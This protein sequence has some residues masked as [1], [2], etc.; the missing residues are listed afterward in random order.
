MNP[1]PPALQLLLNPFH[2]GRKLLERFGANP[3]VTFRGIGEPFCFISI[4]GLDP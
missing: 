4:G 2:L 3:S 1:H